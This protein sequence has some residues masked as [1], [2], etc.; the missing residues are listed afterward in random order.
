M[1]AFEQPEVFE[2]RLSELSATF[3][4]LPADQIDQRIDWALQVLLEG[5]GL[6]RS[7]I[8]ELSADGQRMEI[9]HSQS[10]PP[11]PQLTPGDLSHAFP[12][13]ARM[14]QKGE[15]LQFDRLPEELPPEAIAERD[16]VRKSGLRAMLTLPLR[17][18]DQI[19]GAIGFGS[20]NE[21]VRWTPRLMRSVRLV[22][23]VFANALARKHG[24]HEQ[25]RLRE[26]V[27][28]TARVN[29]M[30]EVVASIAHE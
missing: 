16:H 23:E 29:T 30:G 18:A 8:I 10:R 11:H 24:W 20:F 7:S 14:V 27:A 9:T 19:I 2:E 25:L 15:I 26:Q 4:S 22:G 6:D 5:L 3:V 21:G 13:Y 1:V 17:V 12:W 28:H